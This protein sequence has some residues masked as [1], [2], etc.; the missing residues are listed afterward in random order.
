MENKNKFCQS[1]GM[2]ISKDPQNGGT[3]SDGSKNEIYCSY[4]YQ[5]GTFTF[6][7]TAEEMQEFCKNK[8]VEQGMSKWLAWLLTRGTKRLGRWKK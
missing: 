6:N 7:G 8:M 4:C 2:P 5:N 3:N 1:C